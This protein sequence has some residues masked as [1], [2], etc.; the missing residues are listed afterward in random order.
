MTRLGLDVGSV[1]VSLALLDGSRQL[2]GWRYAFHQGRI[3]ET[4]AGLLAE[5]ALAEP[6]VIA[7]TVPGLLEGARVHDGQLCQIAAARRFHGKPAGLLVV[8][9]ERFTLFHFQEDGSF[10]SLRSNSSC[11]A[12]TGSFLDQQARRLG[13][14]DSAELS[15][16]APAFCASSALPS[17]PRRRACWSRK[18][19]VPAAQ[20]ELVRRLRKPPSA[21]KRNRV[22]R[23]PPT[24]SRPAGFSW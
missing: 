9:G 18:L 21:S 7:S 19:P 8:G 6:V 22:K 24:T 5:L 14:A 11:A 13:L 3:R 17:R 2:L 23:S 12:G 10:R 20:E 16:L 1:A 4:L 15:R